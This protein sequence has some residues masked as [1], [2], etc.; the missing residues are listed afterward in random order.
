MTLAKKGRRKIS[1]DGTYYHWRVMRK[2]DKDWTAAYSQYGGA[3]LD[4][5]KVLL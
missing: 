2:T 1:L 5:G 3:K 4:L